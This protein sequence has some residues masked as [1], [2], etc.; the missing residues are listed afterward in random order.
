MA[1][2]AEIVCGAISRLVYRASIVNT[3]ERRQ[4]LMGKAGA[5]RSLTRREILQGGSSLAATAML[6]PVMGPSEPTPD[7]G[8]PRSQSEAKES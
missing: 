2:L 5:M 8:V 6:H 4:K 1:K 7:G 3:L